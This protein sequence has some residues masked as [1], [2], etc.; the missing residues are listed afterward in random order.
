MLLAEHAKKHGRAAIVDA[1]ADSYLGDEARFERANARLVPTIEGPLLDP[2]RADQPGVYQDA[3]MLAHGWLAQSEFVGNQHAAN[4]VIDQI[5]IDLRRKVGARVAQPLQ[6]LQTVWIGQRANIG[7]PWHI[8]N[9]PFDDVKS[10]HGLE[11]A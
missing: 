9:L 5:A 4:P 8:A 1:A 2:L 11:V 6:D 7:N 10:S 3:Q